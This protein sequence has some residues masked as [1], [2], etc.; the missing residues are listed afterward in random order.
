NNTF[1]ELVEILKN[2]GEVLTEHVAEKDP[3]M[4]EQNHL[5]KEEIYLRDMGWLEE[6]DA[7]VAEVS[8]H[9]TGVGYE[10]AK[11][12]SC[13]KPILCI[14]KKEARQRISAMVG[15]NRS[16]KVEVKEY[17]SLKEARQIIENFLE[18]ISRTSVGG[19]GQKAP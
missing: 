17:S 16:G 1:R 18:K 14:F 13:G 10:I 5:S 6:S 15:G 8:A 4:R 12:E 11:A 3:K 19:A 7:L 9:S 2:H